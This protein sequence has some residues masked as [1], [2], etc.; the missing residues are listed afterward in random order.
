MMKRALLLLLISAATLHS[1]AP[2]PD[3]Y[4]FRGGRVPVASVTL[5]ETNAAIAMAWPESA[6]RAWDT[7]LLGVDVNVD[8][9]AAAPFVEIRSAG[10]IGSPVLSPGRIRTALAQSQFP[11]R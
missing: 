7:A 1:Q 9:A 5:E 6:V 8:A 3:T 11:E 10:P 4:Q 2:P